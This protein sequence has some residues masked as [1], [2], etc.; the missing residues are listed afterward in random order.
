MMGSGPLRIELRLALVLSLAIQ[1]G[2]CASGGETLFERI[3]SLASNSIAAPGDPAAATAPAITRDQLDQIPYATVAFSKDGGPRV[4]LVPVTDNGGYLN[5]RDPG[6]DAIIMFGGAI[7]GSE[8]LG[9]DLQAVQ[10]HWLDPIAHQTPLAAWPGRQ[11]R[12][13]QFLQRDLGRYILT[14]D[15]VYEPAVSE[16]IEIVE[17]TYDLMRVNEVCR[18]AEREIINTYWVDAQTGFIWK[19]EQWLGPRIGHVTI[20]IIRPYSG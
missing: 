12:V 14:L 13:Y 9:F 18:N 19:S 7:S 6:G 3:G 17:L 16:R 1:L 5:Y 15:C 8:S 2:A 4:I 10:H 11:N 20:E